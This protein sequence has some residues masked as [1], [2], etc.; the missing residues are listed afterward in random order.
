VT[1]GL[2]EPSLTLIENGPA[3]GILL[4]EDC[5]QDSHSGRFY[6]DRVS[7]ARG[8]ESIRPSATSPPSAFTQPSPACGLRKKLGP[9]DCSR[10]RV[11][12]R[13]RSFFL[14]RRIT[15]T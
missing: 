8:D 11:I 5:H 10:G 3:M 9:D 14:L 15:R 1:S 6:V 4:A 13:I 12:F 7:W 2:L